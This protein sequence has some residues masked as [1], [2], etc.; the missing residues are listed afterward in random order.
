[1]KRFVSLFLC[2][3]VALSILCVLPSSARVVRYGF[4]GDVTNDGVVDACDVTVIQRL[5]IG[6]DV[7]RLIESLETAYVLGDVDGDDTLSVI[8]AIFIQRHIVN[9][10][11]P[12]FC[13]V[14][15]P[16]PLATVDDSQPSTLMEN[17]RLCYDTF[18]AYGLDDIHIAGLLAVLDMNSSMSSNAIE[19]SYISTVSGKTDGT[20]D[21]YAFDPYMKQ[22]LYNDYDARLFNLDKDALDAYCERLFDSYGFY[23]NREAFSY[24]DENG[25]VHY[26]PGIGLLG[27]TGAN[28][29]ELM[30]FA[31]TCNTCG[32]YRHWYDLD[33]QLEAII[34]GVGRS[35]NLEG[36]KNLALSDAHDAAACVCSSLVYSFSW[37]ERH[38]PQVMENILNEKADEWYAQCRE[39][40]NETSVSY[41]YFGE[42]VVWSAT[43]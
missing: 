3:V 10:N 9:M 6:V 38:V 33:T 7:S 1:M 8:D 11:L 34:R 35:N 30:K 25:A 13:H 14:G 16:V 17:V 26:C 23:V 31:D 32:S 37:G 21:N 43:R 28:G 12:S 27:W 2:M 4:S 20:V 22:L 36:Y 39:W 15:Q 41:N 42:A 5:T 29:I 40:S 24:T 18:K 19:G